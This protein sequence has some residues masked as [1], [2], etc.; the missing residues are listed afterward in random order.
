[1]DVRPTAAFDPW[2]AAGTS[3]PTPPGATLP[4]PLGLL[5]ELLGAWHGSG[6]NAIWLP[7]RGGSGHV[8]ELNLTVDDIKFDL[9][10]GPIPNRGLLQEDIMMFGMTYFQHIADKNKGDA[11]HVEPGIWAVV[12]MTSDPNVAASVVRMASIPHGTT[13]LAQGVVGRVAAVT[14][15]APVDIRPFDRSDP[16]KRDLLQPEEMELDHITANCRSPE[17]MPGISQRMISDPNSLLNEG[18][19]IA[20]GGKA[21]ASTVQIDVS[22]DPLKPLLGGGARSTAFLQGDSKP[23]ANVTEAT[24]TFWLHTVKD[25][26]G[27]PDTQ[28]LQ[29]SQTVLL[30][31]DGLIWPHVT[32]G[33]LARAQTK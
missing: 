14:S 4:D 6:F 8:L 22:T 3:Y 9:I 31:F 19:V 33:T 26:A 32:V 1:M 20:L 29:Y 7:A 16:S 25:S 13:I 21:V 18:L 28:I 15:F 24:S 10:P 12:P 2:L 11:L 30:D 23:N 27:G 5:S 17:R